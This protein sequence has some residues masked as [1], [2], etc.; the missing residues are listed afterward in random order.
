MID[1]VELPFTHWQPAISVH[2]SLPRGRRRQRGASRT[3]S[4]GSTFKPASTSSCGVQPTSCRR[5]VPAAAVHRDLRGPER[6]RRARA[7]VRATQPGA[8][9]P[10]GERPPFIVFVHGGPTSS[11]PPLLNLEYAYFTSRGIGVIDVDYGGSTGY[12]REYRERLRGQW[13]IVDVE[14]CVA[15]VQ[16]LAESGRGGRRAAGHS[17][18]Q[19]RGLDHPG[20]AHPHR[21]IRSGHVVL[22]GRGVAS[23]RARHAR[24]RVALSRRPRSGRYP[25]RTTSTSSARRCPTSTRSRARC[26]CCKVSTIRSCRRRKRRCF[27]MRW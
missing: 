1:D 11:S 20:C 15:A 5:G 2:G 9:A 13:G 21:R 27:A 24:L 3:P 4:S 7:R 25:L 19:R 17:R 8:Q 18:R 22:R 26:C 12:G 23:L 6:P 14:D 10:A 16:A